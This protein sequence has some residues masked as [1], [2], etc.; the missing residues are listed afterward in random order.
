M[1]KGLLKEEQEEKDKTMNNKVA[2][3]NIYQLL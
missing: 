2:I 3:T 1:L